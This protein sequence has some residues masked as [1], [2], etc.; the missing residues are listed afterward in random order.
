MRPMS[1]AAG[2]LLVV[3]LAGPGLPGG[4]DKE[5]KE[6]APVPTFLEEDDGKTFPLEKDGKMRIMLKSNPTTGFRWQIVRNNPEQ[7]KL[8]DKSKYVPDKGG[9]IGGGGRQIFEFLA[10]EPGRSELELVY[11]RPFEK[12]V[13]PAKTFKITFDIK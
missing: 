6:K 1:V 9:K 3:L 2:A 4:K 10:L 7:L 11:R 8:V 12:D 5:P 13:K